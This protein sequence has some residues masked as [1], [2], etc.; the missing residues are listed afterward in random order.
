MPGRAAHRFPSGAVPY[1]I[2]YRSLYSRNIANLM[3]AGRDAS[4][5]HAAMSS[6]RVMGT[7]CSMGQAIGTAAA[8]AAK[9]A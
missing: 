5:T 4:C 2:P 9:R 6:T 8:L 1:G 3:F 7:G